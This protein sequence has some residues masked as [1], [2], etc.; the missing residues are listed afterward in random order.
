MCFPYLYTRKA[1]LIRNF[2]KFS[3]QLLNSGE[4]QLSHIKKKK[5]K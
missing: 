3:S 5:K 1:I 4:L 2:K